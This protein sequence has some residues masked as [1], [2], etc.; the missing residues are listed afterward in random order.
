MRAQH[1]PSPQ[2]KRISHCNAYIYP[3][4]ECIHCYHVHPV[5]HPV[6]LSFDCILTLSAL[7]ALHSKQIIASLDAIQ[8]SVFKHFQEITP[9][10]RRFNFLSLAI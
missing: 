2:A 5:P 8:L 7:N 10:A 9:H 3:V 6:L 4:K 1:V